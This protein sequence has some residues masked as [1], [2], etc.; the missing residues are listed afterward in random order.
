NRYYAAFWT[1]RKK[2]LAAASPQTVT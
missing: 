2:T 1:M